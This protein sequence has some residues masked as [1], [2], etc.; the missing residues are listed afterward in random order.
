MD[1]LRQDIRYA[2]RRLIKSPAFTAVALLTLALGIGANT[3][4]FSVVNAVLLK[5]LP[6]ADPEQLVG[7]YHLTEGPPRDD[8]GTELHGC[9]EAQHDTAGCR[10]LH[11][12][13]HDPDRSRR[14]GS[15][16][17][18]R[19]ERLDLRACWVCRRSWDGPSVPKR[20]KPGKNRVAILSHE[21][22]QRRFGGDPAVIG[23][24]MT[25]RRCDAR[26]R[27]R[28]AAGILVPRGAIPVGAARVLGGSAHQSSVARG[29]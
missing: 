7:I 3:A 19:S 18:R 8:V 15:A 23:K 17:R 29:T 14:T 6:Y 5:P 22:W 13:A 20:T 2:I 11:A 10:G 9:Q 26:D 25:P 1:N 24:T 28:H 12:N 21:L 4:I 16:R 27:R